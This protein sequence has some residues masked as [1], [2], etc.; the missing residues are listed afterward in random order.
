MSE[1][2]MVETERLGC[3][4]PALQH[5]H[6]VQDHLGEGILFLL[7][8]IPIANIVIMIMILGFDKSQYVVVPK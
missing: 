1:N 8:L 7:M 4:H 6:L 3:D 5:L 2:F